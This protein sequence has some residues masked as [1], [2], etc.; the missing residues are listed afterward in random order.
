MCPCAGVPV[1]QRVLALPMPLRLLPTQPLLMSFLLQVVP[2][3]FT[4]Y[5][6]DQACLKVAQGD[7]GAVLQRL[8]ALVPWPRLHLIR[9]H[10][11]L[12]PNTRLIAL[13]S[14]RRCSSGSSAPG[15]GRSD[16][17]DS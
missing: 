5:L 17:I 7:S 13:V 12:A 8:A 3:V 10:G 4:Q 2:R 9:F 14:N 1:R 6:L 16:R 11:V 15:P